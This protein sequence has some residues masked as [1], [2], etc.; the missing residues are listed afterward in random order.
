MKMSTET[1]TRPTPTGFWSA[2]VRC[3]LAEETR[4]RPESADGAQDVRT[5]VDTGF[6]LATGSF[7][8]LPGVRVHDEI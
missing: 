8:L 7:D 6:N 4:Q 3:A 1:V 2:F 5:P